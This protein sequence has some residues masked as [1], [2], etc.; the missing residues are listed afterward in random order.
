MI[1]RRRTGSIVRQIVPA[2][3]KGAKFVAKE[4]VRSKVHA[5]T[6][7]ESSTAPLTT[8][9]DYKTDYRAKRST[10]R[11]RRT[12]RRGK[13]FTRSFTNSWMRVFSAP[14]FAF[15]EEIYNVSWAA[16][17]TTQFQ[18]MIHTVDGTI[19]G[20]IFAPAF[21]DWRVFF[22][23]GGTIYEQAW[24][25]AANLVTGAANPELPY[26]ARRSHQLMCQS[27]IGELTV[28]NTGETQVFVNAYLVICRKDFPS[29]YGSAVGL[30]QEAYKRAANI[31]DIPVL[32]TNPWSSPIL[33]TARPNTPFQASL[34]LRHFK[35]LKRVKFNLGAGQDFS[36]LI[37]SN[38]RRIFG[39]L[40]MYARAAKAGLTY[41]Y[42]FECQGAPNAT[43][44]T[45]AG[46]LTV[47]FV[48]RYKLQLLPNK[49][50]QTSNI[51]SL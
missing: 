1:K 11:K 34:F 37:K 10:K 8:Q 21:D 33:P 15:R 2:A 51:Q 25:N 40:Q 38:K 26:I 28:K 7:T 44:G 22:R 4:F 14:K 12:V 39:M 18:A 19:P 46:Q 47:S 13:R 42:F 31:S 16:D 9:R 3:V 48:K 27:A 30:Y 17:Y 35:I 29:G 24:D 6:Q 43:P 32:G 20:A 45:D 23:E 50:D 5:A 41:G 36:L 49:F